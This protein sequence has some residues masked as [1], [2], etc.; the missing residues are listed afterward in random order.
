MN[1]CLNKNDFALFFE[2]FLMNDS[3]ENKFEED[4][5]SKLNGCMN[6]EDKI[7]ILLYIFTHFLQKKIKSDTE[8]NN[9]YIE[10]LFKL[11]EVGN[12]IIE[13]LDQSFISY[14]LTYS[15]TRISEDLPDSLVLIL[16]NYLDHSYGSSFCF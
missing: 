4:L 7:G 3:L 8:V 2:A 6:W 16:Q 5:Q 10:Q 9:T 11:N 12:F 14:M 15:R 13:S 1:Y